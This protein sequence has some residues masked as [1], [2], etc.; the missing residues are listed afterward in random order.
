MLIFSLV[1]NVLHAA[2]IDKVY[3]YESFARFVELMLEPDT[4]QP[5]EIKDALSLLI[6][7]EFG[8]SRHVASNALRAHA[9]VLDIDHGSQEQI[10]ALLERCKQYG[11]FVYSSFSHDPAGQHKYRVILKLSRPVEGPEWHRFWPRAVAFLGGLA[12][13]DE[14]CSD[15]GHMYY[16]PGGADISKYVAF[17]ADGPPLDVDMI[18][19]QP[20]PEGYKERPTRER[21]L[22]EILPEEK[23]GEVTQSLRDFWDANL[24]QVTDELR[25]R[26][27][28]GSIYDLVNG[29][30]FGIARGIPH[31]VTE[32]RVRNMFRHALD[33]RYNKHKD[34]PDVEG[35]RTDA[36]ANLD[37][38]IEEGKNQPWFPLKTEEEISRPHTDV[39]LGERL[40]DRHGHDLIYEPHQKSWY[41]FNGTIWVTAHGLE[42]QK[43]IETARSITSEVHAIADDLFAARAA[44]E[45]A[46]DDP[47]VSSSTKADLA[48]AF[49]ILSKRAEKIVD[50]AQKSEAAARIEAGL[51]MARSDPKV[52]RYISELDKNPHM[53]NF[54]NG[55]LN[56]A[57]LQFHEHKRSDYFTRVIPHNYNPDA[58]PPYLLLQSL[59]QMMLS[60]QRLVEYL[61]KLIAY[62]AIGGHKPHQFFVSCYGDGM[63]GKSTLFKFLLAMFGMGPSGY[64]LA[65]RGENLLATKSADSHPTFLARLIK[66]RL[67]MAQE[68]DEG[69]NFAEARVKE[70]TGGDPI[71]A[72]KLFQDE[73]TFDPE[74]TLWLAMNHLPHIRGIDEG[75]WRRVRVVPFEASFKNNPNPRLYQQLLLEAERFWNLIAMEAQKL[76]IDPSYLTE[77]REVVA[78]SLQYRRDEDP[79]QQFLEAWFDMSD[80]KA[81]TSRGVAWGAYKSH[82]EDARESPAFHNPKFFCSA[83]EKRFRPN[84]RE[85]VRGYMGLRLMNA[86]ER[87]QRSP[88]GMLNA[89]MAE[90]AK[91]DDKPN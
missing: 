33:S 60:R 10:A 53:L 79:L 70:L 1:A 61:I 18:L 45:Q 34:H 80:P 39:G 85:G 36:Y 30:A 27:Y 55:T 77:P 68:I 38:A 17:G 56:L 65:A 11:H 67:L 20:L 69:R 84:K 6:P 32:A 52:V 90:A 44:H 24:Q 42:Q 13:V 16:V 57:T 4:F 51:K 62:S 29:R 91:K 87:M 40:I 19:Q 74:F 75:I 72:R 3:A 63:N 14:N 49:E 7:T 81:F 12:L 31:I 48:I 64:G 15:I 89:A 28:P 9:L 35:Y 21:E 37:K 76:I 2:H 71:S 59:D 47:S 78:A 25:K 26:K 58:E 83:M 82:Y 86:V 41:T 88:K 46:N 50:F 23:R 8:G 43:M 5:S 54:L 22:D 66:I 73:F